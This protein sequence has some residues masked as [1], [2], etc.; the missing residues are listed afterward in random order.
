MVFP[1]GFACAEHKAVKHRHEH[2]ISRRTC[3]VA[4]GLRHVFWFVGLVLSREVS[5]VFPT[6]SRCR[7]SGRC[8]TLSY[9]RGS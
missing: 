9:V 8:R 1:I 3:I 2:F 6:A 4:A 5:V 7:M